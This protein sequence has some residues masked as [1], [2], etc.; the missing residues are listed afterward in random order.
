MNRRKLFYSLSPKLRFI[1]RRLYHLPSDTINTLLGKRHPLEPP[2]GMIYTGYGDFIA[3]G[4][5]HLNYLKDLAGLQPQHR[6][7]DVG[8]GIGRSAIALTTYLNSQGSYEGFDVVKLGVNWCSKKITPKFPNFKFKYVDLKND[9]YKSSGSDATK[10]TF[11]Y[12][13]NEFD[14]VFLMSVFTHMGI[15]EIDHYLSEINRVLKPGGKCM[16]TFFYFDA[17][18]L[19]RMKSKSTD[20]KFEVDKGHYWLMD[21]NVT[22]ANIC[23]ESNYLKAMI[24]KKG[25]TID[26]TMDGYWRNFTQQT[27][28]YYQD[29]CVFKK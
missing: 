8:S 18:T 13:D 7:L 10:Y 27:G 11:P 22:S 3:H 20:I 1:V 26:N 9:L 6:V 28:N 29:I 2:K 17:N 4:Q 19:E 24:A 21:E 16:A 5:K 25:F 23:I 15:E 14:I 12:N